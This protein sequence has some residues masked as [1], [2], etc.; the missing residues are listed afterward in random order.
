MEPSQSPTV[1]NVWENQHGSESMA[2]DPEILEIP[3]SKRRLTSQG[4]GQPPPAPDAQAMMAAP[5]ALPP[6]PQQRPGHGDG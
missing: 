1:S 4:S 5:A 2:G 3:G 6:K